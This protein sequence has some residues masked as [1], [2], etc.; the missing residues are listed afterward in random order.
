MHFL[1]EGK[2]L[3]LP[4]ARAFLFPNPTSISVDLEDYLMGIF[5]LPSELARFSVNSVI[6]GEYQQAEI[7]FQFV[8]ELYTGFRLLN[9]KNDAL[10]KRFDAVK[11][12]VKKVEEVVYDLTLRGLL[13]KK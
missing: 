13:K 10:R 8:S 7:I 1:Q 5:N 11:Y 6:K 2:L 3:T 4:Q 12:D 9:L